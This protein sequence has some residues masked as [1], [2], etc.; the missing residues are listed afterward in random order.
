[1]K[2][3][4]MLIAASL[5]L[6]ATSYAG[7]FYWDLDYDNYAMSDTAV[8]YVVAVQSTTSI[9]GINSY[10]TANGLDV[11][12]LKGAALTSATGSLINAEAVFA[13][14][15]TILPNQ[16]YYLA[17][18]ILS[19]DESQVVVA[20]DIV[21]VIPTVS[22]DDVNMGPPGTAE[23]YYWTATA[24][25][26]LNVGTTAPDTPGVPEPTAL[27]LLALGVAGVALRRRA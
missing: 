19:A 2:K 16:N 1:M 9:G 17:I 23:T 12:G 5:S 14:S 21:T 3:L 7:A 6:A 26:A 20:D 8:A 4:L 24:D 22:A 25:N 11:A 13:S 10:I 18:F 15:S 27:A